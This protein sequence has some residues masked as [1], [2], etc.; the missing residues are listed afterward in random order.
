M[1]KEMRGNG[2]DNNYFG[3]RHDACIDNIEDNGV[4]THHGNV[5]TE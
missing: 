4:I 2:K 1:G 5:A 3:Y